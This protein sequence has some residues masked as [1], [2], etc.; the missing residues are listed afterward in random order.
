MEP[1]ALSLARDYFV[2][3]GS[4][5]SDAVAGTS[6]TDL[7]RVAAVVRLLT[8]AITATRLSS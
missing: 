6:D 2:P 4:T 8:S 1:R 3:L 7:E 5:M